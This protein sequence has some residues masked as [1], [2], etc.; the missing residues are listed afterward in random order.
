LGGGVKHPG[1]SR[2]GFSFA[3]FQRVPGALYRAALTSPIHSKKQENG[4]EHFSE[5]AQALKPK[6]WTFCSR[7]HCRHV[8]AFQLH[9]II[10][11]RNIQLNDFNA[12][13]VVGSSK[14]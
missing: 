1:S 5:D 13:V 8:D 10:Q 2:L 11:N 12:N 7:E 3:R 6:W 9:E 4:K 14:A